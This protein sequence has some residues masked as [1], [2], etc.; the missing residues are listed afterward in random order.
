MIFYCL[1]SYKTGLILAIVNTIEMSFL[2]IAISIR[3]LKCSGSEPIYHHFV[4]IIPPILIATS[5]LFGIT[6]G[7]FSQRNP[8]V[9][10]VLTSFA[11]AALL[12]LV[13]N[14]L[15]VKDSKNEKMKESEWLINTSLLFGLFVIICLNTI[16]C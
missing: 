12:N 9:L 14:E 2:G 10:T 15:L 8:F 16:N 6:L 1:C 3:L 7:S 4:R 11:I 13:C 5:S